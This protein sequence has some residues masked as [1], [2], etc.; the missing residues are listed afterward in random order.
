MS[1]GTGRISAID[2]EACRWCGREGHQP[3]F[4]AILSGSGHWCAVNELLA[5]AIDAYDAAGLRVGGPEWDGLSQRAV[6]MGL[7]KIERPRQPKATP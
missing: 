4:D 7:D 2:P 1:F 6:A 5:W 3:H